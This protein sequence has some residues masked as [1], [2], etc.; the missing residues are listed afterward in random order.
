MSDLRWRLTSSL[1]GSAL[2]AVTLAACSEPAISTAE[3]VSET[4]PATRALDAQGLAALDTTLENLAAAQRRSGY[5]ALIARD[6]VIQHVS[7]AG[8]ADIGTG[9]PLTAGTM[10][11]IASMTKPVTA[12]AVL[13]LAEDGALSLDQPLADFVPAFAD[14]RVA[15]SVS[16][17]GEGE[18]ET[19]PAERAITI[20]DLLTH[21]SGIGYV[22]DYETDLGRLYL[23]R[24]VYEDR[25]MTLAERIDLLAGLPL[26]FQP[27]ERW[28][29]SWSND[30][31]GLVVEVA[32]GQSLEDFMQA[33]I[34]QPLG[35]D[36]TTFFPGEAHRERIARLYTHDENGIITPVPASL[37]YAFGANVAAGGAGLFS[38]AN[39]YFRFAQALA[40]GGELDGTRILS[41]ESVDAMTQ[42]HVGPDRL[43]DQMNGA[44]L[45]FG[46]SVGVVYEGRGARSY[47]HPADFGWGGYFD[48]DFFVSPSTGV[49][50]LILAQQEPSATTP[51]EGA[52]AVFRQ[53]MPAIIGE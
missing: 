51:P 4:I 18:I 48:T 44:N 31:L 43:P 27:G 2:L 39:D 34:F 5:V 53:L 30:I 6:G 12:V 32:S 22:F 17:N 38:T 15:V 40:N 7:E 46:Y 20:E 19:V 33:R 14:A 21:T 1:L 50:A 3:A 28:Y 11:R 25:E 16:A 45:G 9:R 49:V 41:R 13:Q 29:Y 42:V 23:T 26:Y 36:D 52:R 8:F 37:D 35:M 47:G 24:N 10:V